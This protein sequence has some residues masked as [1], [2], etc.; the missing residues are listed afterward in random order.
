MRKGVDMDKAVPFLRVDHVQLAMPPGEEERARAFYAGILGMD[1]IAKPPELAQRGGAWFVSGD[2]QI[3][4]G[5][6]PDFVAAKKAH[7]ALRCA[8]YSAL[9]ESLKARY[10]D[11][12]QDR[13]PFADGA[14]HAYLN[15]PFGNRIEIIANRR[16]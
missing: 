5:V 8:D 11:V 2:V 13:L 12:Q 7:P 3:H 4:L 6:E 15:D 16:P 10:V 14:A 9:V 1:E